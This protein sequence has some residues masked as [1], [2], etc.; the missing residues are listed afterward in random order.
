[1]A[2]TTEMAT[3]LCV[4]SVCVSAPIMYG[5]MDA[6]GAGV[7]MDD[8]VILNSSI[9][10]EKALAKWSGRCKMKW[11]TACECKTVKC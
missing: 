10:G 9:T 4:C 6:A 5:R 2:M 1:M 3:T 11:S 7:G 8:E